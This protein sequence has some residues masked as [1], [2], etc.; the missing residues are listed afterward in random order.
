MV[1]RMAYLI[2]LALSMGMSVATSL[3][4]S[5]IQK[6]SQLGYKMRRKAS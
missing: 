3:T 5:T 6:R 2:M 4:G 1:Q